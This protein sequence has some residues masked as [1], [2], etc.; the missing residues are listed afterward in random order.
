MTFLQAAEVVLRDAEKPLTAREITERALRKGLIRTRGKTPVVTMNARL[1]ELSASG[2][3]RR[4]YKQAGNRRGG[5]VPGS[6]RW[7]YESARIRA[8]SE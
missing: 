4:I 1:Y 2:P 7:T 3:I 5:V 8:K 6:V